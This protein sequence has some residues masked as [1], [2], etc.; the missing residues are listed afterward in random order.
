MNFFRVILFF[1]LIFIISDLQ[2]QTKSDLERQKKE[3]QNDIKKIELKLS[4]SLKQKD[5]IITICLL[6]LKEIY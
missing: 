1:I 2:S 6:L 4:N 5:L 3:I